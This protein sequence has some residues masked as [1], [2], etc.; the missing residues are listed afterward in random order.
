METGQ[1]SIKVFLNN[2][3]FERHQRAF[4]NVI[5]RANKLGFLPMLHCEDDSLINNI[6]QRFIDEGKGDLRYYGEARPPV[7]EELA[8]ERCVAFSEATGSPIYIVH[9]SSE[10]A[11]RAAEAGKARGLP[12]FTEVRHC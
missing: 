9:M 11:L 6:G 3:G 8:T 10:R 1:A 5:V 7:T 12:I 2:L 4:L